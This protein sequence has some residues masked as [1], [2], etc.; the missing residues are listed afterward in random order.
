MR[1]ALVATQNMKKVREAC[2][3]VR[4]VQDEETRHELRKVS[5][6]ADVTHGLREW[7]LYGHMRTISMRMLWRHMQPHGGR[8]CQ[9]THSAF[10]S[11]TKPPMSE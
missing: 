10:P 1:K 6:R 11:I 8:H 7:P 9:H 2:E 4:G 3:R 5:W